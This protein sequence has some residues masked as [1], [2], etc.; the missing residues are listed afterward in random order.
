MQRLSALVPLAVNLALCGEGP[1]LSQKY[2]ARL[3]AAD[4]P[5]G[6]QWTVD[7]GDVWSLESFTYSAGDKLRLRLGPSTVVLGHHE[8]SVLWAAVFPDEPG[9]LN[10]PLAGD[11]EAVAH[12]WLRFHPALL[13][14]LFPPATVRGPAAPDRLWQAKRLCGWKM[15]ASWQ[16]DDLPVVPTRSSVVV[17]LDTAGGKRRFFSIDTAADRVEYVAAFET[18]AMPPAAPI[19]RETALKVFDEAWAAFDREYALFA[20][21]PQVD[22]AALRERYRPAAEAATT[23]Y[24]AAA[25]VAD[26]LAHL[27]DL[28]AWVRVGGEYVPGYDRPRPL[29]ASWPAI[30]RLLP[31]LVE[32]KQDIAWARTDDGIGYINVYRLGYG[33]LPEFFD[34]VLEKL[35]DTWG[36]VIDLR[37]NGGGDELLARRLAG[38][39]LDRTRVYSLNQYRSGPKHT[40]LGPKLERACEPRGPWRYEAPV[41][42]LIGQR[43]MSSAES[44]ALMLAQAPQVVTMGDRT[45]GSSA[46]PRSVKLPARVVVNLPRWLDMDPDG[47]P[48]DS[49]GVQPDVRI[50]APPDAFTD[51]NDPVLEAA[52]EHL[53]RQPEGERRPG[54]RS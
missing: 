34:E 8:T 52:L 53:R 51:T 20:I 11:G 29:N 32:T 48:L 28:H 37:F 9:T 27:E 14:E 54:R 7:A 33:K 39:F 42:V 17:D 25:A 1:D 24:Q 36:L 49:A 3:D 10:S 40:D 13:G 31:N 15:K 2:P 41:V 50:A 30:G 43:T 22:W 35:A 38:R 23:S 5:R 4:R 44:F 45:A 6:Y 19:D 21:K 18:Q 46:N 16:A 12:V 47:R 26:M